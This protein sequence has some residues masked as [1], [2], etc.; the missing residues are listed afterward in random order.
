MSAPR[1]LAFFVEG[2]VP[3]AQP[4][5]RSGIDWRTGRSRVYRDDSHPIHGWRAAVELQGRAAIGRR[6]RLQPPLELRVLFAFPRTA[7][8][9]WRRRPMPRCWKTTKPDC[10][11]LLKALEDALNGV[12]WDDDAGV[13]RVVVDRVHVAGGEAPGAHVTIRELGDELP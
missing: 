8:L 1:E 3:V 12:V 9:T 6:P 4:R 10:S 2:L 11:N 13:C 7:A 5:H